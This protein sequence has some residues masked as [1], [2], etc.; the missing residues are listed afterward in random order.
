MQCNAWVRLIALTLPLHDT[1]RLFYRSSSLLPLLAPC[2]R[3]SRSWLTRP[4]DAVCACAMANVVGWLCGKR[5]EMTTKTTM[6]MTTAMA[7]QMNGGEEVSKTSHK[8]DLHSPV[9]N[10]FVFSH[11]FVFV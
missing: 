11:S 3:V 6:E 5:S 10:V 4:G 2:S 9:R 8:V 1:L 7:T